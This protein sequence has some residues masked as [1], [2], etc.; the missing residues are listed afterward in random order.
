MNFGRRIF[1]ANLICVYLC[2]SVVAFSIFFPGGIM[3]IHARSAADAAA[4][5]QSAAQALPPTVE[6]ARRFIGAV[7]SR[8]LDLAVESQRAAWVH[9][10]FITDDTE[11]IAAQAD[12]AVKD[13]TAELAS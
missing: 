12:Q 9:E 2:S 13:A 1:R 4:A 8:L 5:S 3:K 7:E 6:E 11:A 10:T